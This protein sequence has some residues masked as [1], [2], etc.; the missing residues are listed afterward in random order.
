[1]NVIVGDSRALSLKAKKDQFV[2]E[3]EDIWGKSGGHISSI[4]DLINQNIIYHH[5]PLTN[6]KTHYYIISGICDIT[7]RMA[8]HKYQ[9]IIFTNKPN[10]V[11]SIVHQY[12]DLI[13][14]IRRTNSVP[15]LCTVYP[16]ELATWNATRLN[17]GKTSH[18]NFQDQYQRM[19][20]ELDDTIVQINEHIC[21]INSK[22]NF[23]TPKIHSCMS[24]NRRG[25]K[26]NLY[27]LLRDGCHPGPIMTAKIIESIDRAMTLNTKL[28]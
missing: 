8:S 7:T 17:Q 11:N 1:M 4:M 12:N 24:R 28:H 16:M 22:H 3:V 13:D 9:E 20:S 19:Q 27:Q 23:A 6:D 18:L 2:N 21:Q 10:L 26:Y 15:I 14:N 5:P 25:K